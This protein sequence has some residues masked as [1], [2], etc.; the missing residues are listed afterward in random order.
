MKI[1]KSQV[2]ILVIGLL[3]GLVAAANKNV[4]AIMLMFFGMG[5]GLTR[6]GRQLAGLFVEIASEHLGQDLSQ[7]S[8]RWLLP[9]IAAAV[10]AMIALVLWK[11]PW[12]A[13][14]GISIIGAITVAWRGNLP[15]LERRFWQLRDQASVA[16]TMAKAAAAARTGNGRK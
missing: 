5:L 3:V 7:L 16:A 14:T 11:T 4:A 13:F 6:P 15:E 9:Y 1:T 12:W 10:V 2:I 8:W